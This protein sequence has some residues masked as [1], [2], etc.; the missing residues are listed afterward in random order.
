MENKA[1]NKTPFK[2]GD[3]VEL[4]LD[5]PSYRRGA[6][7]TVEEATSG[8]YLKFTG[9]YGWHSITLYKRVEH[10]TI[11][12]T[13]DG[14]IGKAKLI[15]GGKLIKEVKLTRDKGDK[16]DMKALA[17]YAVQKLIPDDGNI[18][19][20]VKAG[21][22][23]SVC[24]VNSATPHYKDGKILEF[25][26]GKCINSAVFAYEKFNTL[27]EINKYCKKHN[28]NFSVLELHRQ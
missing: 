15:K 6:R 1:K 21:Y 22:T 3:Q 28:L 26:G 25:V 2:K 18:L 11:V 5:T 13:T 9:V 10:E 8:G 24:V 4:L 17:A 7:F 19:I 23:G 12:I 14:N 16:H 27:S 20:N